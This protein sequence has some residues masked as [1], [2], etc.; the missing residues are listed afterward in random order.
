[1]IVDNEK[2]YDNINMQ[3]RVVRIFFLNLITQFLSYFIRLKLKNNYNNFIINS[4]LQM[5]MFIR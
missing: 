1:M 5:V 3:A 4:T 2:F